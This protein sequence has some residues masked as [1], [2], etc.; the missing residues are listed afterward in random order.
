[1][2]A[3]QPAAAGLAAAVP[4]LLALHL[5]DPWGRGLRSRQATSDELSLP[6]ARQSA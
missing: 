3:A 4:P 6:D 5:R 2:L 1:M